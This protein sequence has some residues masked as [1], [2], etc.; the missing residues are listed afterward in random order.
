MTDADLAFTIPPP[1]DGGDDDNSPPS[2]IAPSASSSS[3][4]DKD[5]SKKRKS[6]HDPPAS[7]VEEQEQEE[8]VA[9]ESGEP[10]EKVLSHKEKRQLKKRKLAAEAAGEDPDL[11]DSPTAP[12]VGAGAEKKG[13]APPPTMIGQTL[14]GNTPARSAH[15]VWVGNMNFATHPREL[16]AWFAE[17]GLKDVTRINMPNGKRSHE[18]NRGCV[19]FPFV[20]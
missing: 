10:E 16:L 6:K 5:R 13:D 20:L 11:I 9:E 17:R 1:K 14:V 12:A 7:A 2:F 15:G 19:S 18:N 8:A 4:K 3:H